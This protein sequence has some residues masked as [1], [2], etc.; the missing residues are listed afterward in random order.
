MCAI[1]IGFSSVF[2]LQFNTYC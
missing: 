2:V 1:V